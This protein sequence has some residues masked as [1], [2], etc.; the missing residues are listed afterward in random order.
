MTI[1]KPDAGGEDMDWADALDEWEQKAFSSIAPP[2]PTAT[3]STAPRA[4]DAAGTVAATTPKPGEEREARTLASVGSLKAPAVPAPRVPVD[5]M[6]DEVASIS[7]AEVDLEDPAFYG[8]ETQVLSRRSTTPPPLPPD[9]LARAGIAVPR[10]PT[11]RVDDER[12]S[13]VTGS[14]LA[15]LSRHDDE[16]RVSRMPMPPPRPVGADVKALLEE[17]ATWL[18]AEAGATDERVRARVFLAL[19]EIRAILGD[20]PRAHGFAVRARDLGPEVALAHRQARVLTDPEGGEGA[21]A[22]SSVGAS[23]AAALMAEEACTSTPAAKQHVALLAADALRLGGDHEGALLKLSRVADVGD[24]RGVI[25]RTAMGLATDDVDGLAAFADRPAASAVAA[26]LTST[27]RLRG[28]GVGKAGAPGSADSINDAFRGAR[29]AL[30]AGDTVSAATQVASLRAVPELAAGAGWLASA[31]ATSKD[32]GRSDALTWLTELAETGDRRAS[33]VLAA[34]A[35]EADDGDAASAA[36]AR[37]GFSAADEIALSALLEI[38][39]GARQDIRA[40]PAEMSALGAALAAMDLERDPS[41]GEA[42]ATHARERAARVVGSADSRA[43]A[44][45]ARLLAAKAR[46]PVLTAALDGLR[47]TS[48]VVATALD[49]ELALREGAYP[50]VSDHVRSWS[51]GESAARVVDGA[52][53]AALV[54]ERAGDVPRALAAYREAQRLDRSSEVALRAVVSLHAETDLPGE[55]NELADELGATAQGGLTR[56]EAVIREDSVDDVTRAD[57]LEKAHRAAP[58]VPFASFLAERIAVRAGNVDDALR[59]LEERRGVETDPTELAVAAL[60]E[61]R[62]LLARDPEASASRVAEAHQRHPHHVALRELYERTLPSPPDDHAQYWEGQA[63]ET[64]GDSRAILTLDVAHAY[65]RAGDTAAVLRVTAPDEATAPAGAAMDLVRLARERAEVEGGETAGLID[66]ILGEAKNT[67]DPVLQREAYERLADIDRVGRNDP[68]SA[69]LWHNSILEEG[70]AHLPSLRY[71]EHALVGDGRDDELEPIVTSIA[72]TLPGGDGGERVAHADLAARLRSRGPEGDWE[73]T[74]EVAELAARDPAPSLTSLRLLLAHA[75]VRKDDA[76]AIAV[77]EQIIERASR[78]IEMAALRLRLAEAAFRL[79]DLPKALAS[80]EQGAAEDPGDLIA[81]R[82]LA[83]VKDGLG[84]TVGAAEAHE[85]LA[86]LSL[87]PGHCLDAWYDA[88]RLWSVGPDHGEQAVYALEQAAA[89]NLSHEDVFARLAALYAARGAHVDLASLLDRRIALAEDSDERVTLEVERGRALLAAGDRAAARVA[90]A[91][92][93]NERP[94]H[95]TALATFAELSAVEEDWAAA[96]DAWVRLARLLSTPDEQ[97]AVYERLGDLY[98]EKAVHLSRAETAYRE[99]LKR[100][101]GDAPTLQR[102][103]GV[104]RRQ[105]DLSRAVEVQ[106]ELIAL[107]GSPAEK[108]T[109]TLELAALYEDPGHDERRAEQVLDTARKELP[110]DVVILRAL[111]EFYIRHKQT[112]A[113]NILLDRAAADARRA[114]AAGRFAPALFE[115]M[116]AV[117]SLRGKEDAARIVGASLLAIEAKPVQVRGAYGAALDP[118]IDDLLAPDVLTSGLRTLFHRAGSMLDV[119]APID[120]RAMG[121]QPAGPEARAVQEIASSLA[122]GLGLASPKIF[123]SK[124]IGRACLPATSDP[125]TLVI[126]EALLSA[127]NEAAVAFIVMRA[128]KLVAARASAL[129]RTTSSDLAVLVPAWLQAVVPAWT[130]QGLNPSALAT[131]AKKVALAKPPPMNDELISLGLE[132]ASQLGTRASTLGALALAWANRSALLGAGDPNAALD[133]LAWSL[134]SADGAPMDL[135]ARAA[136]I[137]RTHEAKDLLIFSIGDAYAEAR[138][139]YDLA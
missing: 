36:L 134:G 48:P 21:N 18:E 138:A 119:A 55:L 100:A 42:G 74:L 66:Q 87:V 109:R 33:R 35:V 117:F 85:A 17:H 101:P 1:K 76:R 126:G 69:L 5:T 25:G 77:T 90:V 80:L 45:M 34:R 23:E 6:D 110:T 22:S 31:L 9:V 67:K 46:I 118:R 137:S 75:R 113:M 37:G 39:V 8:E 12:V 56:L 102:L 10:A 108:R 122:A 111:A 72:Q 28:A 58:R 116:G 103:V 78:P 92:A 54:A 98:S 41:D 125:P 44:Q 68:A 79:G 60:R 43:S 65:E 3:P 51:A 128:M 99:V 27:L 89:I 70:G 81:Y 59:W 32:E 20:R 93:L 73:S 52:L 13:V 112:P 107:A 105:Q 40:L 26:A 19:S 83:E 53:A 14:L 29:Q 24:V 139:R 63:K 86:R 129:V 114:F 71:L 30:E 95:T 115:I 132:V 135:A 47:A 123:V 131:A 82:L 106:Q 97:R 4:P 62:L 57:L 136:W 61:S 94:D 64:L 127:T 84:D 133:A 88:A 91:S 11:I 50:R 2:P 104:Y 124:T 121:A 120:L 96:E 38:D 15:S 49:L 7:V 16:P 130:P